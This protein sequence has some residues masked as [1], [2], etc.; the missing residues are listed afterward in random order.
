LH[1]TVRQSADGALGQLFDGPVAHRDVVVSQTKST[2][3]VEELVAGLRVEMASKRIGVLDYCPRAISGT[4]HDGVHV[5]RS[6]QACDALDHPCDA[7]RIA[8]LVEGSVSA[9]VVGEKAGDHLC[10]LQ[11]INQVIAVVRWC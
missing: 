2:L 9:E 8:R 5:C 10:L 11:E 1:L 7:G 4:S 3:S 6:E